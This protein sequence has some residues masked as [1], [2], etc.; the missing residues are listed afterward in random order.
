MLQTAGAAYMAST[1][2]TTSTRT[3]ATVTK[4]V[5]ETTTATDSALGS[6]AFLVLLVLLGAA[7]SIGAVGGYKWGK[8]S[9]R[10]NLL[11]VAT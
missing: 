1:T 4:T 6:R 7:A 3:R 11:G 5:T 8:R 10:K 2:T 9:T